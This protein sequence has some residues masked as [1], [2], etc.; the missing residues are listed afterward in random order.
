MLLDLGGFLLA[1]ATIVYAFYHQ[2]HRLARDFARRTA[3]LTF[4]YAIFQAS[5]GIWLLAENLQA[6][7]IGIAVTY[8]ILAVAVLLLFVPNTERDVL[9]APLPR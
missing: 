4:I 2:N 9:P 1:S 7:Y 8:T 5:A 6:V 3:V